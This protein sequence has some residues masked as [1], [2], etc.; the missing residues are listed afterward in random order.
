MAKRTLEIDTAQPWSDW[1]ALF[2]EYEDYHERVWSG[3]LDPEPLRSVLGT[4]PEVVNL[5]AHMMGGGGD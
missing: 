5:W 4:A 2:R 3:Q 1:H